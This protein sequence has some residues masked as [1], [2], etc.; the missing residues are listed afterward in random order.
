MFLKKNDPRGLHLPLGYVHVYDNY[1]QTSFSMKMEGQSKPTFM[2]ILLMERGT[3]VIKI[4]LVNMAA[5]P[6][7][8]LN[9]LKSSSLEPKVL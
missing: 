1:F 5:I 2:W 7:Y 3:K 8:G 6:I 4:V 9:L